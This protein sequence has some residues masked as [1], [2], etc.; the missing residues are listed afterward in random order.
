MIVLVDY[1]LDVVVHMD[2]CYDA[3]INVR[4]IESSVLIFVFITSYLDIKKDDEDDL[5]NLI[6]RLLNY[7]NADRIFNILF[8]SILVRYALFTPS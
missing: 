3:Y 2:C 1:R 5:K 8:I 7:F 4:S 6:G